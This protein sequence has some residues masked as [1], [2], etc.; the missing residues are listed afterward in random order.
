MASLEDLTELPNLKSLVAK[1]NLI[2][3]S[4]LPPEIF[5]PDFNV[6]DLQSNKLRAMPQGLENA[7]GL[8]VLNLA[9][10]QIGEIEPTTFVNLCDLIHLDLSNNQLETLPA[11]MRRL[12]N[13]RVMNLSNNPLGFA[14]LRQL[15][16]LSALKELYLSNTQR[17]GANLPQ[18]LELLANTIEV[19]DLSKNELTAIPEFLYECT[20][21]K[22]LNLSENQISEVHLQIDKWQQIEVIK[23]SSN[24]LT[25]LPASLSKL[26]NVRALYL[27]SNEL[28]FEG[29]PKSIGKL[30]NLEIFSAGFNQLET[31]P[32]GIT[33]CGKLRKLLINNNK[34]ITLPAGIHFMPELKEMDVRNNPS[35]VMPPKPEK[36]ETEDEM[37]YTSQL[38]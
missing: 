25:S 3:E 17:T 15:P 31:V 23:L 16:S 28:D 22:R 26:S 18:S 8:L 1:S 9:H 36:A 14:Q 37:S 21:L 34:L 29:I 7:A 19:I 30:A 33:R 35:L 13:L 32:E 38:R 20:A 12:A 6:L 27:N 24:K 10:N 2:L 4:S 11:Q 5:H